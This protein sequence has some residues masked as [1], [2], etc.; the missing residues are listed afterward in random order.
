MKT[1][2]WVKE[3]IDEIEQDHWLDRRFTKR[4]LDF[5]PVDEWEKFDFRYTGE[6]GEKLI[7]REWNEE[8]IIAQLRDDVEFGIEKSVL[9]RGISANLMFDVVKAWCIILEN[10]LDQIAY[11]DC[12]YG[13]KLF[14]AVDEKY[15]FGLVKEDTF[16][17]DFYKRWS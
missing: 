8:N 15:K 16:D 10:G 9:H 4:F 14:K 11:E 7:P 2:E 3:H 12:W 13:D 17:E 6:E 1:L 5:I